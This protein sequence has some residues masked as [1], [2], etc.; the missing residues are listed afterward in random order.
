[1]TKKELTQLHSHKATLQVEQAKLGS[2]SETRFVVAFSLTT[3]ELFA[4]KHALEQPGG[5]VGKDILAY[6]NNALSR[7]GIGL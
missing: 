2:G 6:F 5:E 4:L 1:M 3:G 7:S